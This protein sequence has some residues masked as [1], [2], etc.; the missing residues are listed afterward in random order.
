MDDDAGVT[1]PDSDTESDTSSSAFLLSLCSGWQFK[2]NQRDYKASKTEKVFYLLKSFSLQKTHN[3]HKYRRDAWVTTPWQA[4]AEPPH[5]LREPNMKSNHWSDTY[6][7]TL[8]TC[9]FNNIVKQ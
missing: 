9:K 6:S 3:K 4:L 1:G 7:H 5:Q 2:L 8:K